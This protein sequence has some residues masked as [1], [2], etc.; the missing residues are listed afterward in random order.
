MLAS[1]HENEEFQLLASVKKLI[2]KINDLKIIIA[3]RHP[4]RSS[5]ILSIYKKAGMSVK[6]LEND[7][8]ITEDILIINNFGNLPEYF[9][10]SDIVFL[11]GSFVYKGGH[12][13]IEPAM[14]NCVIVTGPHIYNW[15]NIYDGIC[16]LMQVPCPLFYSLFEQGPPAGN[17]SELQISPHN[18][19]DC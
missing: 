2:K 4:E 6:I 3:P 17:T 19:L 5:L 8:I 9:K 10:V 12:N 15:K 7:T 18:E 16:C 1:T 11:G 13:P 14:N